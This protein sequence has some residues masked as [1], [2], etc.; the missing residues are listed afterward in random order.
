MD[1][2]KNGENELKKIAS[3]TYN[4]V[5]SLKTNVETI[6]QRVSERESK[7]NKNLLVVTV[8]FTLII[9]TSFFFYFRSES[10]NLREQLER[11]MKHNEYLANDLENMKKKMQDAEDSNIKAHNL[12]IALQ[13]GEPDEALMMYNDFN[14]SSLSRLERLVIDNKARLIKEKAALKRYKQGMTLFN[15]KSYKSAITNFE[16]SLEMSSTGEHVPALFYHMGLSQYRL[17]EYSKAAITFDRFLFVSPEKGFT[18]DKAE[19][20]L[21]ICYEKMKQYTRA[22]NFYKQVLSDQKLHRFRP[23]I[24]ERIK[25]L[26]KKAGSTEEDSEQ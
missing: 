2:Q 18:Y 24:E 6:L 25:I 16:E 17:K 13:K 7:E 10:S 1:R 9:I 21:G 12:Y 8:V 5:N 22:V 26:L 20:L 23:T 11:Q 14:L 4:T 3:N 15:R 19:L